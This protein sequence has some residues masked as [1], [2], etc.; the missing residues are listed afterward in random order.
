MIRGN[1]SLV[2][3]LDE[4]SL[5]PVAVAG[6]LGHLEGLEVDPFPLSG[7]SPM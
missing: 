5:V 6:E 1:F 4:W 2:D 7:R 3:V